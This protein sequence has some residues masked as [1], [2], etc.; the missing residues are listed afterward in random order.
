MTIMIVSSLLTMAG[1]SLRIS[2]KTCTCRLYAK[3]QV[4][5][6][7]YSSYSVHCVLGAV[8]ESSD[9]VICDDVRVRES[10][11]GG[12]STGAIV[13]IVIVLLIL[14]CIIGEYCVCRLLRGH[15]TL[16]LCCHENSGCSGAGSTVEVQERHISS[17]CLSVCRA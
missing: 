5:C 1:K 9:G 4:W 3:L 11:G 12:L 10:G 2:A 15:T 7:S 6:L 17:L 14:V 8:C 16:I 13:A